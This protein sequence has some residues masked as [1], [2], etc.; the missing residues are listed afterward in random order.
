MWRV[1]LLCSLFP[2]LLHAGPSETWNPAKTWIFAV[3]VIQFDDPNLATYPE[4]GRVDADM[5]RAYGRRGV[6][7]DHIVFLKDREATRDTIMT[8]LAALLAQT[9]DE[10]TLIFY[11]AGHGSRDYHDPARPVSFITFDTAKTWLLKSV[12]D[13]IEANFRGQRVLLTA[14]CCYS[15][16]LAEEARRRRGPK[17][18]AVLTS[19]QAT[20][21]STGNWTFTQTLTDLLD[22]NGLLDQDHDGRITLREAGNYLNAEMA[23]SEGQ[24][25][26]FATTGNFPADLVMAPTS[27]KPLTARAGTRC[28][29]LYEGKWYKV[30]VLENQG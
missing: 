14:D 15:G 21:T 27:G 18:F 1:V 20:S 24:L 7:P 30:K 26:T 23:F 22:G 28:E 9:A 19:A 4:K 6:P 25:A 2:L 17:A 12:L 13:S 16:G 8:R 3:G 10:D 5:I 11:Y 29:A